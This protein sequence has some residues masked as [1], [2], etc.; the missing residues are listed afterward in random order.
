MQPHETLEFLVFMACP[1][2]IKTN[3]ITIGSSISSLSKFLPPHPRPF[4]SKI[5]WFVLNSIQFC[6]RASTVLSSL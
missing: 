4:T 1:K 2:F 3:V 5:N 6:S